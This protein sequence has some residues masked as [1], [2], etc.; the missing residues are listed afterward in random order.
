MIRIHRS[1]RVMMLAAMTLSL[2]ALSGCADQVLGLM[3]RTVEANMSADPFAELPDGLHVLVCGAGGPLPFAERSSACLLVIAG[4][5]RMLFDAGAGSWRNMALQGYPGNSLDRV[6]LTHFHSDHIDGL[7]EVATLR[8]A[9]GNWPTPLPVHGP[10]GVEKVVAGFNLAYAQD[11]VYRFEHH[12]P[13]VTPPAGAG[14]AAAPFA[15]PANG[16]APVVYERGDLRVTAFAV[17]HAPVAPAVGYRIEYA[18][19]SIAIS[20]DTAKSANLEAMARGV[21]VLFHE[22]L[23]KRLVGVMNQAAINTGRANMAK[24]TADIL[25]YHASPVEAAES[26]A[27]AEA[28]A[29]VFYHVVPPMPLPPLEGIFMDGVD[30]AFDGEIE[31][32]VDGTF[33]SLPAG[34]DAI[35]I[36]SP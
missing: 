9:G 36:E 10:D 29:L 25:D 20:G 21:D 17:D 28:E 7:G 35:E 32:S 13:K 6:F 11:Q 12:G 14:L 30:D 22:A 23:S 16:E 15:T 1:S 2:F 4:E 27:A 19:R 8:W 34:G 18:G 24:V 3:E 31:L 26:A 5:E 33:V